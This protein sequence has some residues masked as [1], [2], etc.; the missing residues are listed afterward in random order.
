MSA[1]RQRGQVPRESV[2]SSGA[3]STRE[4]ERGREDSSEGVRRGGVG[5]ELISSTHAHGAALRVPRD[6]P[7]IPHNIPSFPSQ[8]PAAP[9]E[10]ALPNHPPTTSLLS[11]QPPLGRSCTDR[12]YRTFQLPRG[13]S[14]SQER[15]IMCVFY[16][17]YFIFSISCNN[18]SQLHL[19]TRI[20]LFL[21]SFFLYLIYYFYLILFLEIKKLDPFMHFLNKLLRNTNK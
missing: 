10:R 8:S 15:T 19:K 12:L 16:V 13:K 3:A 17:H 2:L 6:S 18:K 21:Y 7:G 20:V 14:R 5:G 4:H 1:K 9:S 11:S